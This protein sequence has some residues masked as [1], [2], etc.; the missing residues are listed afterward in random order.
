MILRLLDFEIVRP[1]EP[2]KVLPKPSKFQ[3]S[4]L[5][6]QFILVSKSNGLIVLESNCLK[7]LLS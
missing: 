5:N 6:F 2:I 4:I 3:F 1:L 7:I